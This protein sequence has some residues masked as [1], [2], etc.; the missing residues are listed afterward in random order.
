MGHPI[1]HLEIKTQRC[2]LQVKLNDVPIADAN[3]SG[4]QPDW[5]APPLNPYLVGQENVLEVDVWPLPREDGQSFEDYST[6]N[7]EGTVRCYEK[8]DPVAPGEGPITLELEIMSEL[9]QRARDAAESGEDLIVPQTF[10]FQFDNDGPDFS[11]ELTDAQSFEDPDALKTYALRLR[12]LMRA[13]DAGAIADEMQPKVD[14]YAIAFDDDRGVID[15]GLR[16]VLQNEYLPRGFQT[17]FERDDIEVVSCA[18]GRM[19][20]VR[21]VGGRPL[22]QTPPDN[23]GLTM[24]IPAIVGWSGTSLRVVR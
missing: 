4:D 15:R 9:A 22:I 23:E 6:V 17:D 7:V 12:D 19:W 13:R 8:N 10:F 21:R 11:A 3:S 24:Q 2:R 5:F 20:E 16:D 18:G 1:Y 14:A